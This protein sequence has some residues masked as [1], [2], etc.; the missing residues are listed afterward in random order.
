MG[1]RVKLTFGLGGL[2]LGVW[3]IV[4]LYHRL[5]SATDPVVAKAVFFVLLPFGVFV[6]LLFFVRAARRYDGRSGKRKPP[7]SVEGPQ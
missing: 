6:G 3:M 2:G 7:P 1:R 5:A 4:D